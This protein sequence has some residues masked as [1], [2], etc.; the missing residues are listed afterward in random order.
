ML[1]KAK[2]IAAVALAA[3][4]A[5][6]AFAQS[7][8]RTYGTGNE[9]PTYFDQDGSLQLGTA[10]QRGNQ[11]A[12]IAAAHRS[13]LNLAGR[14]RGLYAHAEV[15]AGGWSAPAVSGYDPSIATQR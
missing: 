4:T 10:P 2:L 8:S 14:D 12:Q 9:T 7:Y 6:P 15:P 11:I 13:D 3:A 5:T 1:T